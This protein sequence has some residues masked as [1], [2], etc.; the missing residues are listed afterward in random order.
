MCIPRVRHAR[1]RRGRAKGCDSTT[2]RRFSPGN[3]PAYL[4]RIR[5]SEIAFY[6][7]APYRTVKMIADEKALRNRLLRA[8]E[9]RN[10]NGASAQQVHAAIREQVLA[11]PEFSWAKE[12]IQTPGTNWL[13]LI[14]IGL[15]RIVLFP[16]LIVWAIY[17]Q[18]AHELHEPAG[19]ITPNDV[20]DEQSAQNLRQED[21]SCQNQFSQVMEMKP[22]FARLVTVKAF[23]LLTRA[24]VAV[25][26][27]HGKLLGIPTIHFARWIMLDNNKRMLFFSNF[28]GSWRQYHGDFI[29]KSGWGLN[30]IFG[31]TRLF[32]RIWYLL[33]RGAYDELHFLGWSRSTKIPTQV[34][35]A[36]SVD[37]SIKN[38]ND[39]TLIRN[40][41][42]SEFWIFRHH[43]VQKLL[44]AKLRQFDAKLGLPDFRVTWE[45]ARP[46]RM[47]ML[48]G[49]GATLALL[50]G[51]ALLAIWFSRGR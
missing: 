44:D 34:W 7:G 43:K 22:G 21:Y 45:Y 42:N 5:V 30:G 19:K 28:D 29:D 37:Q 46:S 15:V 17:M 6:Q 26:F 20:S 16:V 1:P 39:N 32:P 41:L 4:R 38:I 35:F 11:E 14:L 31:N 40:D 27:V 13:G 49:R 47:P 3:N 36:A 33:L 23:F 24:L 51:A 12:P 50:G 25:L 8:L 18:F 10:W 48:G 9:S 2:R